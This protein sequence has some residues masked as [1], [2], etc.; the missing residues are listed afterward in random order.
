MQIW[1]DGSDITKTRWSTSGIY[2]RKKE[3]GT[4]NINCVKN[5]TLFIIC[6]ESGIFYKQIFIKIYL[7]GDSKK[8]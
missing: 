5:V 2:G 3:C 8:I 1:K 4:F 6:E 7:K